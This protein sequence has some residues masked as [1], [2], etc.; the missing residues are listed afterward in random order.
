MSETLTLGQKFLKKNNVPDDW[1]E[2]L[3]PAFSR[4]DFNEVLSLLVQ[5]E[6][7]PDL[8]NVLRA[9]RETSLENTRII[10]LG[11][12]PYP[13]KNVATGLAFANDPS[14][15]SLSPSL[16]VIIEELSRGPNFNEFEF[17]KNS[18]LLHWCKQGILLLNSALTVQ[19]GIP[20]SHKKAWKE[21]MKD[22]IMSIADVK[23]DA[24]LW[25]TFGNQAKLFRECF[26]GS[27]LQT[28]VP[29]HLHTIHPAADTYNDEPLFRGSGIFEEINDLVTPPIK[30][31]SL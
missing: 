12:D 8:T 4:E 31:D 18:D 22:I 30:W 6:F 7:Q 17:Y 10:F 3:T 5:N 23:K 29:K 2:L 14:Q 1:T 15:K 25:V 21:I 19:T 24:V 11:Q 27:G 16:N 26:K 9:F 20:G 28:F 13:Q